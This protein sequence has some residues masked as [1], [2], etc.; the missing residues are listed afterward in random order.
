MESEFLC[1]EPSFFLFFF[2]WIGIYSIKL[3][4]HIH[5]K[6]QTTQQLNIDYMLPCSTTKQ[7]KALIL[8]LLFIFEFFLI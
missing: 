2:L 7:N 1:L 3:D 8:Y 4:Q 6:L 5:H